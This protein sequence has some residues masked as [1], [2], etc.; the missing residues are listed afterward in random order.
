[1]IPTKSPVYTKV[2]TFRPTKTPTNRPTAIPTRYSKGW[3]I[4]PNGF[5]VQRPWNLSLCERYAFDPVTNT[6]DMMVKRGDQP[7]LQ[8]GPRTEMRFYAYL[9]KETYAFTAYFRIPCST[10]GFN[11]FQ[12]FG[13]NSPIIMLQTHYNHLTNLYTPIYANV[14]NYFHFLN[15]T[16]NATS[17]RTIVSVD[18]A[19]LYDA[20]RY[21]KGNFSCS[22]KCGVY[23]TQYYP[24]PTMEVFFRNITIWQYFP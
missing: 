12:I 15:V 3:Q 17:F 8:G 7:H 6:H 20:I 10:T 19:V 21:G 24:S 13:Y 1:M 16:F 23:E 4:I 14:C 22:F 9:W 11:L 2:P 5:Y 18:G